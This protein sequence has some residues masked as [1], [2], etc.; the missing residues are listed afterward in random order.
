[1]TTQAVL[2]LEGLGSLPVTRVTL[3]EGQGAQQRLWAFG[4]PPTPLNTV[5][6][7]LRSRD[8]AAP[9]HLPLVSTPLEAEQPPSLSSGVTALGTRCTERSGPTRPVLQSEV[10]AWQG[11]RL[12]H[13]NE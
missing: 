12:T 4:L 10:S 7:R 11:M 2:T 8:Q 5:Y 9:G 13:L 3:G 1:M 6:L